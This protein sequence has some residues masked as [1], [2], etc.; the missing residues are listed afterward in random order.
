MSTPRHVTP[1][2]DKG[3][4]DAK[5]FM[6][7]GSAASPEVAEMVNDI[8][9]ATNILQ[10]TGETVTFA[11]GAVG[12]TGAT[13]V[14]KA[15]IYNSTG[16]HVG[17]LADTSFSWTTG[18][19]VTTQVAWDY[20]K[21]DAQQI[22]TLLTGE[23]RVDYRTGKILYKKATTATTDV[24]AYKSRQTNMD[25]TTA[26]VTLGAAVTVTSGNV[27]VDGS[28]SITGAATPFFDLSVDNSAQTMKATAGTLYYVSAYNPNAAVAWIQLL[29]HATPTIGTTTPVMVMQIP[30][31][32]MNE[33]LIAAQG[34]SF[35][36]AITYAATT[37]AS[38]DVAPAAPLTLTAAFK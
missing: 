9:N 37:T 33:M 12:T 19:L 11:A 7:I 21:T 16:T 18:T 38:G 1:E 8:T 34:L 5:K 25:I 26:S 17:C 35:S 4:C 36:T 29:N 30:A 31:N 27:T 32:G 15:P 14:D 22:A 10:V 20:T 28:V 3:Y 6:K 23:Y 13:A 24:A 2:T